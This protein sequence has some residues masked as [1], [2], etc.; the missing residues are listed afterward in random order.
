MSTTSSA[1]TYSRVFRFLLR[2]L[3]LAWAGFWAWFVLAHCFGESPPPPWWIPVAWLS[4]LGALVGLSWRWPR[5][6]GLALVAAGAWA[7]SLF[8]HPGARALLSAPA[9]G[10]GLGCM[11]LGWGAR[12]VVSAALLV[13]GLALTGCLT[14]QDPADLPFRTSSILRHADG[15]KQR[16]CLIEET[17]IGGFPCRGWVWWHADGSLDNV[18][19]ARDLEVQGHALPART[20]IFLDRQGRLAHAWLSRDAVIDGRPCR[21]RWKIDTAFHPN[22]RLKA[23][24]PPHTLEIDGVPCAASVFH[25]VYLHPDGRLRRCKLAAAV[26]L[27]GRTLERGEILKRTALDASPRPGDDRAQEDA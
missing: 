17:E 7:A 12:R 3:L 20:R 23:F 14:P 19:L 9:I 2:G 16:A 21:G 13:L 4:S 22:G 10:L 26:T 15:R 24:F 18:E 6:G 11:A 27:D 1:T 8:D 25:P 5:I